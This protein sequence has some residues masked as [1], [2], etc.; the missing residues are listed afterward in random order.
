MEENV[1]EVSLGQLLRVALKYWWIILI[2]IVLGAAIAFAY[3]SFF[4]A[5]TYTTYAKVGVSVANM[6]D[7]QITLVGNSIA[8]QGSDILVSNV[9]LQRAADKLNAY[10][11]P[12]NGG[13]AYRAYSPDIILAM[14]KT[15]TTEESPYFDVQVSSPNPTEAKVVCDF[16]I[17][18]FCDA[19]AEEN[20]INDAEGKVIHKPVTPK[21]PS[22]PNKTLSIVIGALIGF[23]LCFGA[24]LAIHFAKDALDS[25]DWLIEAYKDRIPMLAVIPDANST[26]RAYK[27]YSAK[28]GYGYK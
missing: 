25:E 11:F 4:V 20:I 7:Y 23:V 1:Y 22:L 27:K 16:V 2:A 19:L 15:T 6:S 28:Y 17:E 10:S 5:P 21:S 8:K 9:T 3:V 14:I 18:A 12:E 13:V 26:G 24:L